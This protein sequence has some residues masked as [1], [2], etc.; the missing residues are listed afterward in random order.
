MDEFYDKIA[1][2]Y[3]ELHWEEQLA[4]MVEIVTSL[5][6]DIPHR[7]ERLLDVGCGSGISTSVWNCR[8]V[9][10]DPSKELIK[11]ATKKYPGK[12]FVVGAAE[13][14]PFKTGSFDV[15]ISVT[16]IHNF[17]DVRKGIDEM[18]RVGKDRFIITVLKKSKHLDQIEKLIIMNF[19]IQKILVQEK[20][21]IFLCAALKHKIKN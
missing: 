13:A 16:S 12:H 21:I 20:D 8:C 4:K 9:G 14:L 1:A 15:V 5:T 3:D 11:I 17:N 10:V 18:K 19:R 6:K 2:G 7:R